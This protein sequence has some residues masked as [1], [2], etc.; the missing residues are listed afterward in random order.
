M[1]K[2][3]KVESLRFALSTPLAPFDCAASKLDQPRFLRMQLQ[4]ELS[5]TFPQF[6][7]EPFGVV[8]VCE[9]HD[10]S[11]SAGESPPHALTD[12]DV[13]LA[14]HPAPIVQPQAVPPFANAQRGA[15]AVG[16]SARAN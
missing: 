13:N 11:S 2:A 6:S 7:P 8:P 4:I 3:E 5:Q 14:A 10:E 15:A 9:A 1:R 12:P 16:Q